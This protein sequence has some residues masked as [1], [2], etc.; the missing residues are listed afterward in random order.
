[1]ILDLEN[2]AT[3]ELRFAGGDVIASRDERA[4]GPHLLD[5]LALLGA[6]R[7]T[8]R[9]SS[10]ACLGVACGMLT[11]GSR[12]ASLLGESSHES[13]LHAGAG[14]RLRIDVPFANDRLVV[15]LS[16]ELVG[17]VLSSARP[18]QAHEVRNLNQVEALLLP[19]GS[20]TFPSFG[21]C[22]FLRLL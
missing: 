10:T 15:R 13:A 7:R 16:F 14:G 6:G 17:T 9:R 3:P 8:C 19:V 18:L 21:A 11:V 2:F 22:E 12:R 4:R 5:M 1:M 20:K